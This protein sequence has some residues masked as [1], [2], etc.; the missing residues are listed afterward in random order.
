M[1]V[2]VKRI[3]KKNLQSLGIKDKTVYFIQNGYEKSSLRTCTPLC[4][5]EID[6]LLVCV[7]ICAKTLHLVTVAHYDVER[8]DDVLGL[9]HH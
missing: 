7:T 2:E 4:V 6:P 3:Q 9:M 5:D 1:V 8:R